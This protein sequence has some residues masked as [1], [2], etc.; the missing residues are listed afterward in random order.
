[1]KL[2][3]NNERNPSQ[4]HPTIQK[5]PY[6]N[7]EKIPLKKLLLKKKVYAKTADQKS[8]LSNTLNKSFMFRALSAK[9]M[10]IVI[11]AMEEVTASG[12][13]RMINLGDEGDFLFVVET[14]ALECRKEIDGTDTLLK[15][16][17]EG[18]DDAR[19]GGWDDDERLDGWDRGFI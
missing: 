8:R 13:E 12:G 7:N 9:E 4:P 5:P 14:G 15:T 16:V 11:D 2:K 1:M 18:K 6:P 3:T 19:L 17:E 10:N